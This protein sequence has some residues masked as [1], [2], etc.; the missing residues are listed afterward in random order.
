VEGTV[1]RTAHTD[2]S[3]LN[4]SDPR[5]FLSSHAFMCLT[6]G[7]AVFLDLKNDRYSALTQ[8]ESRALWGT[9]AGWPDSSAE[10]VLTIEMPRIDGGNI[11]HDLHRE[12]LITQQRISGKEAR[13]VTVVEATSDFNAF[14]SGFETLPFEHVASFVKAWI[15]ITLEL[16]IRSLEGMVERIRRRSMISRRSTDT[17]CMAQLVSSYF[18]LQP[19]FFSSYNTCLRNSLTMI[20]YF[21]H[22]DIHPTWI[23]G[24]R[25]EPWAAHSW[26]QD[27]PIVLNDTVEHVRTYTPILAI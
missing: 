16:R 2:A 21:A 18:K 24:V 26:V 10:S 9:V 20:E 7:Y 19:K 12:G 13:P 25:M 14:L 6:Q 3:A 8:D 15:R 27:G 17:A 22:H 11:L 5:Y 4:N 1:R 23:F